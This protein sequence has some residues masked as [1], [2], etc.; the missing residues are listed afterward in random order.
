MKR[1]MHIIL[2][3]MKTV[4]YRQKRGLLFFCFI[5]YFYQSD[6]LI[7]VVPLLNIFFCIYIVYITLIRLFSKKQIPTNEHTFRNVI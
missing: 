5:F 4:K 1:N 6:N 2:H 7:V 3:S